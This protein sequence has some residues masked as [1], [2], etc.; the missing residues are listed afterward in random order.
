MANGAMRR[1]T[2][3]I[4]KRGKT[5]NQQSSLNV[6]IDALKQATADVAANGRGSTATF[7]NDWEKAQPLDLDWIRNDWPYAMLDDNHC[8]VWKRVGLYPM[9]MLRENPARF[10]PSNHASKSTSSHL[11]DFDCNYP[12]SMLQRQHFY[13]A[14]DCPYEVGAPMQPNGPSNWLLS[15]LGALKENYWVFPFV[16]AAVV[17]VADLKMRH[18]QVLILKEDAPA[19]PIAVW[20]L[21]WFNNTV[22]HIVG[23]EQASR[24]IDGAQDLSPFA[25]LGAQLQDERGFLRKHPFRSTVLIH[26]LAK[27]WLAHPN[28]HATKIESVE[29]YMHGR[30][31]ALLTEDWQ[32]RLAG[33]VAAKTCKLAA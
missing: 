2:E 1:G 22:T 8:I 5:T 27:R 18:D 31:C 24:D 19:L 32:A 6:K 23:F 15:P 13:G 20:S 33:E 14:L 28:D 4:T 12:W 11:T 25:A 10:F 29:V 21:K 30:I 9:S 17:P 3:P 26:L 7:S 16:M